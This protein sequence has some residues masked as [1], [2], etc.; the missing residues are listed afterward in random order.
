MRNAKGWLKLL[1][2]TLALTAAGHRGMAGAD[3]ALILRGQESVLDMPADEMST[4]PGGMTTY[5]TFPQ[6]LW[7]FRAD[8]MAL[9]RDAP[10]NQPFAA[11]VT[12][13]ETDIEV[14][15]DPG[16]E[17]LLDQDGN[18][19]IDENGDPVLVDVTVTE[20]GRAETIVLGTQ[21]LNFEFQ[22]G[23]RLA[24]GRMLGD[25]YWLEFTFFDVH[26]WH[27]RAAVRDRTENESGLPG[28]LYSPFT[29]FGES[30]VPG[31][32]LDSN[33][34]VRIESTSTLDN[35]ELNLWHRL[36]TPPEAMEA[37]FLLGLRYM[38]IL[39]HFQY[40]SESNVPAAVTT[41]SVDT[42]TD[43]SLFGVQLGALFTFPVEPAW[44]IDWELKGAICGN[45]ARQNTL[46]G[47]NG[48]Q[49]PPTGRQE[50]K[51]TFVGETS[52]RLIGQVTPKLTLHAGYQALWVD[53][54]ALASE[55][56]PTDAEILRF[57]PGRLVHNGNL[58]YHGPYVGLNLVW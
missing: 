24:L 8:A 44:W 56:L 23:Y 28:D 9:K 36:A 43:N 53:G 55:N 4:P 6:P 7:Y 34:L 51:T 10:D 22:G 46:Y 40:R 14:R 47:R 20:G 25:W 41:T 2:V 37:S 39:E 5:A 32:S 27:E 42:W 38:T 31:L 30:P 48:G 58:V 15:A 52:V 29:D 18:P 26:D 54:L 21:D 11:L 57:G 45:Q 12:Q 49:L 19:V 16:G 33:Y 17:P 35:M 3:D 1:V 13:T 50:G